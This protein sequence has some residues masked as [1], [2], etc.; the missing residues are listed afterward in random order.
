MTDALA[1][2]KRAHEATALE[3]EQAIQER[4]RLREEVIR[5]NR[6][7]DGYVKEDG[8]GL[9]QR[10]QLEIKN[11]KADYNYANG[12]AIEMQREIDKLKKA[13]DGYAKEAFRDV[14]LAMQPLVKVGIMNMREDAKVYVDHLNEKLAAL[15]A[16]VPDVDVTEKPKVP[17]PARA[18][19]F[20]NCPD[21][22][23][24]LEVRSKA[25]LELEVGQFWDGEQVFCPSCDKA[26]GTM[27][28]D[29]ETCYVSFDE[30]E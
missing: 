11:L 25:A 29:G 18:V 30:E 12:S 10:L 20:D 1:N 26:V 15:K 19:E 28:A 24:E 23:D 7:L 16:L 17:G 4:N 5:L 21:C 6:T 3:L 13:D 8:S 2:E 22:G 27:I 14:I 9:V